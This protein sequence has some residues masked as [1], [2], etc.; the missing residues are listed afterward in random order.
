MSKTEK[1]KMTKVTLDIKTR[2][3]E[4]MVNGSTV[5]DVAKN[6]GVSESTVRLWRK[7]KATLYEYCKKCNKINATGRNKARM[8]DPVNKTVDEAM[9]IWYKHQRDAGLRVSGPIIRKQALKFSSGLGENPEFKASE[10]WLTRWKERHGIRVSGC[11]EKS[12]EDNVS[13]NIA[14]DEAKDSLENLI[15]L[16]EHDNQLQIP[17][18]DILALHRIKDKIMLSVFFRQENDNQSLSLK[19]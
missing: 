4:S 17:P 1:R 14:Y 7:Q 12:S 16:C 15:K 3:L 5:S 6:I 18:A 11:V 8:R 2:A 13:N 9:W 10:G 19:V